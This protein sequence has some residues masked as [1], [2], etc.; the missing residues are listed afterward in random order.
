MARPP[1][2]PMRDDQKAFG[3]S[4]GLRDGGFCI[5]HA[6]TRQPI[7][8]KTAAGVLVHRSNNSELSAPERK[9][10]AFQRRNIF[11]CRT[12]SLGRDA[13]RHLTKRKVYRHGITQ[14]VQHGTVAVDD[15]LQT[16]EVRF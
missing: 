4:R 14:N 11:E 7:S 5:Q 3:I 1:I 6:P 9:R 10:P 2:R 16:R 15:I 13:Q 8:S 12:G